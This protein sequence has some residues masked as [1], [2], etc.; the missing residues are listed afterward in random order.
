M[1]YPAFIGGKLL[2]HSI[3][4]LYTEGAESACLFGPWDSEV[5]LCRAS[6]ALKRHAKQTSNYGYLGKMVSAFFGSGREASLY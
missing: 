1:K 4:L 5:L 3:E 2:S 6:T